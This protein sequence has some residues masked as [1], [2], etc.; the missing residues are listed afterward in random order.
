M[1]QGQ[2]GEVD[3][4]AHRGPRTSGENSLPWGA[5]N[6]ARKGTV[7]LRGRTLLKDL[8]GK[9]VI[10]LAIFENQQ[11]VRCSVLCP[12]GPSPPPAPFLPRGL[13]AQGLLCSRTFLLSRARWPAVSVFLSCRFGAR[14]A[15][16]AASRAPVPCLLLPVC[17]Q[18]L[19]SQAKGF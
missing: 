8:Y 2:Q 11:N 17:S 5:P 9:A 15:A 4:E 6:W 19:L 16:R 13:M 3:S 7:L 1:E 14:L 18:T 12:A 10:P